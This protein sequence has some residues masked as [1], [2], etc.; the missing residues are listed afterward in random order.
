MRTNFTV[1]FGKLRIEPINFIEIGCFCPHGWKVLKENTILAF[2]EKIEL[3]LPMK[4]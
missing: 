1:P 3:S 4:I 2:R